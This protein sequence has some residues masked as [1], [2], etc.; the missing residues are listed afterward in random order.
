MNSLHSPAD[1][2]EPSTIP[3]IVW[4]TL[5][6]LMVTAVL[7]I[8]GVA[9]PTPWSYLFFGLAFLAS[10]ATSAI[11]LWARYVIEL[12]EQLRGDL[13][14]FIAFILSQLV[15][16]FFV[17]TVGHVL[18]P[19]WLVEF[20]FWIW[21]VLFVIYVFASAAPGVRLVM[22]CLIFLSIPAVIAI[23]LYIASA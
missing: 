2:P 6:V 22:V 21:F 19:R 9:I 18:A 7:I 13:L 17:L 20:V 1:L 3:R 11:A 23:D 12:G 15:M 14:P 5:A 16:L 10:A 4:G 8:F